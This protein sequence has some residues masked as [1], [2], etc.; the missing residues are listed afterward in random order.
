MKFVV[1][2]YETRFD[3]KSYTLSKMSTESYIRDA[4]FQIHG[5]AVK[6]A[7]D[8]VATWYDQNQWPSVSAQVDWSDVFLI[9]HHAQFDGLINSHHFNIHPKTYGCTLSM[10]R[11]MLGNHLSV[12]LD[13]VRKHYGMHSKTTPYH[14]F[15]G[16]R[17]EEL[18]PATQQQL[19]AGACDEV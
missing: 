8:Q 16:K 2:D 3:S 19:A 1:A 4:R 10:A 9:H 18:S 15:E 17:W 5:V 7:P 13:A 14:L 6:W 12:S 11:L